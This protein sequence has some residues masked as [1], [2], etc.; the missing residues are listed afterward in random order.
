MP[1]IWHQI[2]QCHGRL[3]YL[4]ENDN[5]LTLALEHAQ[6][7]LNLRLSLI[8]NNNS[9]AIKRQLKN[10]YYHLSYL[11]G[12][13]GNEDLKYEYRYHEYELKYQIIQESTNTDEDLFSCAEDFLGLAWDYLEED[14]VPKAIPCCDLATKIL[15]AFPPSAIPEET[16]SYLD[17]II[18]AIN[19]RSNT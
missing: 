1:D 7:A 9:L 14:H 10:S 8:E 17:D 5:N 13:L 3:A 12:R 19:N 18:E 6:K 16:H 4:Y 11:N 15:Q 2:A